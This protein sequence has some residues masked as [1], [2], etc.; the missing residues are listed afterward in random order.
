M[1]GPVPGGRGPDGAPPLPQG[2]RAGG[3]GVSPT[4]NAHWNFDV[5]E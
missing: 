1:A 2:A 5:L 4:N 3:P